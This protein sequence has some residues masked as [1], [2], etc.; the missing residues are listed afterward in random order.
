M[1]QVLETDGSTD[2]FDVEPNQSIEVVCATWGAM[3]AA[4]EIRVTSSGEWVP[5]IKD[6]VAVVFTENGS[7]TFATAC[8]ARITAAGVTDDIVIRRGRVPIN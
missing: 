3:S 8:E 5:A 2:G 7:A 6:D 1:E 4:L